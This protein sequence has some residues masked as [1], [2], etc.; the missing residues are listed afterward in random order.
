MGVVWKLPLSEISRLLATSRR[1]EAA[2]RRLG[3]VHRD[4]KLRVVEIL[5]DAQVGNAGHMAELL[6]HLVG[7]LRDCSAR[8]A[9]SI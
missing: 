3:A 1:C 5:L 6:E 9:P 7:D 4:V 8:S 2:L